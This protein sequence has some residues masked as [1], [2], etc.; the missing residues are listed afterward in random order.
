MELSSIFDK[1]RKMPIYANLTIIGLIGVLLSTFIYF[2]VDDKTVFLVSNILIYGIAVILAFGLTRKDFEEIYLAENEELKKDFKKKI[3]RI[4]QE[5]DTLTLEKT[6]RD[7]TRTL[8]TNA[9]EYFKIENIKNEMKPSAAIQ[10]LQLDKYGQIIELLADFSLILPDFE[11]NRTIVQKEI[12]HQIDI[13]TIDEKEFAIFLQRILEKY[14]VTVNK[15]IREKQTQILNTK[16]CP[17]CAEK[18]SVNAKVCRRCGYSF[19]Q[20][21]HTHLRPVETEVDLIK[22]GQQHFRKGEFQKAIQIF[23]QVIE[24]NPDSPQA[25]YNRGIVF[26]KLN[27]QKN[28]LADFEN[29]AML[30]HKK[31]REIL[32][33]L[34]MMN[35]K[36]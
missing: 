24:G 8:I 25:F 12:L 19:E 22:R 35:N 31:A 6:I 28:A 32:N 23:N 9:L 14:L 11:E 2:N 20:I 5:H 33:F 29:A 10:N 17:K 13:Y 21:S 30:G 7:G 15:K 26:R 36:E 4:K 1:E 3:R 18:I 16:M 34:T 27:E